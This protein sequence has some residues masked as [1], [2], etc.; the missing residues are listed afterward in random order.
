MKLPA[1]PTRRI[2]AATGA[3]L[4]LAVLAVAIVVWRYDHAIAEE[5]EATHV[6]ESGVAIVGDLRENL[7]ER[8]RLVATYAAT[9]D[10]STLER[11]ARLRSEFNRKVTDLATNGGLQ[12]DELAALEDLRRAS[13]ARYASIAETVVP[14]VRAGDAEEALAVYDRASNAVGRGVAEVGDAL[15]A[16]ADA[17]QEDAESARRQARLFAALATLLA[18]GLGLILILYSVRLISNLLARI[19]GTVEKLTGASRD[20]RAAA[21]Q[22]AAATAEQ[23]SAIAEV[24]AAAEELSAT[25]TA[26]ASS[27]RAGAEAAEQT[28]ETMLE[29]QE[30]VRVISERSLSL[31]ERTQKIG[32]VLELITGIA[33]QTNLLALNA[34]IE[35]ARAGE[36]GR[37]FAVVAGEV[38]RLAERSVDSTASIRDIITAVQ[39][40]TN[41]TIMATEQGAKR[42]DEVGELMSSTAAVL[43]DSIQGTEQQQEAAG[44]VSSTMLEIRRAVDDLASEQR[45][46][47]ATAEQLE[48]LTGELTSTLQAYGVQLNGGGRS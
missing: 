42:V 32:E 44:Q 35:A 20:M 23:S 7:I 40:E 10:R 12:A 26:I 27:A 15:R 19:Q 29:V 13:D 48:Q 46:R 45:Q 31:G 41:A 4:L 36:A 38:R 5:R 21:S 28:G 17:V 39:N 16:H 8:T 47:A 2:A 14:Q 22:A 25:A 18:V 9:R 43:D 24:T 11:S 1:G 37:G 34:A 33:E 3:I 30:Q 6:L